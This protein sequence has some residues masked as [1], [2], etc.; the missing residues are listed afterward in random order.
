M[1]ASLSSAPEAPLEAPNAATTLVPHRPSLTKELPSKK[2]PTLQLLSPSSL[3]NFAV[4]II[5]LHERRLRNPTLLTCYDF[6]FSY[7]HMPDAW[8][9]PFFSYVFHLPSTC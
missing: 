7:F 8:T 3:R 6:L 9:L 4:V 1:G 2:L 5:H